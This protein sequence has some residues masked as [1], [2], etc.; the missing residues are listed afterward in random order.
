MAITA[1]RGSDNLSLY[2]HSLVPEGFFCATSASIFVRLLL[3]CDKGYH[4]FYSQT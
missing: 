3:Y 4:I 2:V 1:L